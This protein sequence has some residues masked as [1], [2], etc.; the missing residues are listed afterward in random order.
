MKQQTRMFTMSVHNIEEG[1]MG[2]D[3]IRAVIRRKFKNMGRFSRLTNFPHANVRK[4][5]QMGQVPDQYVGN[6]C[7]H[8][9]IPLDVFRQKG[10]K[11][12]QTKRR[13]DGK[14]IQLVDPYPNSGTFSGGNRTD[15]TVAKATRILGEHLSPVEQSLCSDLIIV[16]RTTKIEG[17]DL[18]NLD[19]VRGIT[20]VVLE[21]LRL[22]KSETATYSRRVAV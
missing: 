17:V 15:M 1:L 12:C 2:G 22:I 11:T 7:A 8:L 19:K 4:W 5:L 14:A 18:D 9:E 3:Y 16:F 6:F 10:L 20:A 13:R 21:S